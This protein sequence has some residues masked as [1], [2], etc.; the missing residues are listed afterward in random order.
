MVHLVEFARSA[1][2]GKTGKM[3][4]RGNVPDRACQRIG[5]RTVALHEG[6]VTPVQPAKAF[7]MPDQ[8]GNIITFAEKQFHEVASDETGA[9]VTSTLCDSVRSIFSARE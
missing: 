2:L 9:P 7:G 3:I 6:H 4:Y 1:R 5:I 8:T